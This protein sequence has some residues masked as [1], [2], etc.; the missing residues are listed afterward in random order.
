MVLLLARLVLDVLGLL[1]LVHAG[2]RHEFIV[3]LLARLV[4]DVLGLLSLVHAG[5]RHEFIVLLL[6]LCLSCAGPRLKTGEIGLDDLDH[7]YDTT[8]LRAHALVW[9]IEDLWLLNKRC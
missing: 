9:L 5:I 3:L 7:T 1:R 6:R 8:V 4:L 2:I